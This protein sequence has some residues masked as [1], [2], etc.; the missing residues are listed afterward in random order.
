[1]Q[2]SPGPDTDRVRTVVLPE[3]LDRLAV[4]LLEDNKGH[5]TVGNNGSSRWLFP[6]GQPGRNIHPTT[7]GQRLMATGI[8]PGTARST[9]MFQLATDIPAAALARLPGMHI[10]VAVAWQHASGGDWMSYGAEASR[11]NRGHLR[12]VP[13]RRSVWRRDVTL[14]PMF[15]DGLRVRCPRPWQMVTIELQ[16]CHS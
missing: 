8:Q 9:E 12:F 14:T 1:M 3:P 16:A 6:G 5:A 15:R 7:L 4:E 2:V 10:D 13:P 11:R